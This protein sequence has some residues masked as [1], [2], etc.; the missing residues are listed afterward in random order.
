MAAELEGL[1]QVLSNL[2]RA[3]AAMAGPAADETAR[4]LTEQAVESM[5]GSV[6][7]LTGHLRDS[8]HVEGEGAQRDVVAA[9]DYAAFVEFGTSTM[10]AQPFFRPAMHELEAE[11]ERTAE[12][13]YRHMVP[14][15]TAT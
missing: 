15:L 2:D 6:P 9:A 3:V 7:V 8:I 14:G 1:T 4:K 11:F 12:S 5:K 10:A 13:T